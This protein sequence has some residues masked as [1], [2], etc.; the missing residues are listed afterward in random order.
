MRWVIGLGIIGGTLAIFFSTRKGKE[1]ARRIAAEADDLKVRARRMGRRKAG[2]IGRE[3]SQR[4]YD[5]AV[6]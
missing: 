2:E 4:A 3:I 1:V 5:R 6:G